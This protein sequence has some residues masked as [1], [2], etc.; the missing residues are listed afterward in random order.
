MFCTYEDT[1]VVTAV[2][3]SGRLSLCKFADGTDQIISASSESVRRTSYVHTKQNNLKFNCDRSCEFAFSAR[4]NI[5][6]SRLCCD[7]SVRLSD[8][9]SVCD[10][11]AL[12]L[13][14]A[15]DPGYLCM[16]G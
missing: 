4:C 14:G 1:Y 16:L 6:I 12:R 5:Y 11:C 7:V 3:H 13:Q 10:V 2:D 15:M 8:R 9:L